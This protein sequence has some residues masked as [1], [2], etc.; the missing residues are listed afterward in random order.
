MFPL[1]RVP[2]TTHLVMQAQTHKHLR[3]IWVI[4]LPSRHWAGHSVACW[5]P[6]MT[7]EK[8]SLFS[9]SLGS[10]LTVCRILTY[11]YWSLI[12]WKPSNSSLDLLWKSR[13]QARKPVLDSSCSCRSCPVVTLLWPH[14]RWKRLQSLWPCIS[15]AAINNSWRDHHKH[16]S[17]TLLDSWKQSVSFRLPVP[18]SWVKP[19]L[20][21]A[22]RLSCLSLS[23]I[24]SHLCR[25][26]PTSE[27][28]KPLCSRSE[29]LCCI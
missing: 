23:E 27:L 12:C 2:V 6:R 14:V 7:P 13:G 15:W 3:S 29:F 19:H 8:K 4:G 10:P 24:R 25:A 28:W 26:P 20:H 5:N 21:K 17:M 1:K 22:K 9:L 18:V 11:S 16:P